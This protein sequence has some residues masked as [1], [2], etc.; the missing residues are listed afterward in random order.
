MHHATRDLGSPVLDW[1]GRSFVS[2]FW[3]SMRTVVP[4]ASII[5]MC[6]PVCVPVRSSDPK[7]RASSFFRTSPRVVTSFWTFGSKLRDSFFKM[8]PLAVSLFL[9]APLRASSLRTS[10]PKKR[11]SPY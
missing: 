2:E 11:A 9:A 7:S 5:L 3:G 8:S 1:D 6:F 10:D 4:R